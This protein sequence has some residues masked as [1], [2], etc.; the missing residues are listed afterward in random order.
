MDVAYLPQRLTL[1]VD[2]PVAE[3]LGVSETLGA[4]RAI[5][6]GDVIR[7]TST[8]SAPTGTSSLAPMSRWQ[9]RD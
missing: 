6:S 1:D 7:A 2:R 4:L 5:E 3:L 8:R 9:R